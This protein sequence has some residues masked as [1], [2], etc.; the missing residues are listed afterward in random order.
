MFKIPAGALAALLAITVLAA[1]A[2]AAGPAHVT[3]RVE[4]ADETLVPRT[5]VTTTTTPVADDPNSDRSCKGTGAMGAVDQATHGDYA[6]EWGDL[7]FLLTTIRGEYHYDPYPADPA[8]YWSLWVNYQHM[9][10]GLCDPSFELQEGDDVII[11]V[12][13]YSAVA[14]CAPASPLRLSNVPPTVKP[15][16]TI[17]VK[18]DEY[19]LEDPNAFPTRTTSAPSVGATITWPGGVVTTGADGTA[20]LRFGTAGP[21]AIHVS[22]PGHVRTTELTCVTSGADGKCGTKLPPTAVVGTEKPEDK[23]APVATIAGLRNG[24][25]YKRRRAPRRIAGSVT[26]DPSGLLSVRLSIARKAHGRCWVFDGATERFKRHRCGGSRSFRIGDREQWSYLL[27]KR[28]PRGR[29]A[30]RAAVIDR[31]GNASSTTVVIRV[32]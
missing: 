27:P 13:C 17:T 6:G 22:K 9:D 30:I 16:Q 19:G 4:G 10:V 29:Y 12:D 14:A 3:V 31:R 7:G 21:A 18:V 15:G 25:V 2:L 8:R 5:A 28:L 26:P 23:T 11:L 20:Q 32:R 24:K 1:P